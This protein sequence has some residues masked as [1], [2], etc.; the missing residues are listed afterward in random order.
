MRNILAVAEL[1]STPEHV[2][3][4]LILSISDYIVKRLCCG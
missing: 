1:H 3:I 2:G 4:G